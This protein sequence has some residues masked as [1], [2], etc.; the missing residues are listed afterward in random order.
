MG[1]FGGCDVVVV[2]AGFAGLSAAE[3]LVRAGL[4][5]RVLEAR[6]RVGGRVLTHYLPDGT[7]LDLGGQWIGPSQRNMADLVGRYVID[8]YPTPTQGEMVV[9]YDGRRLSDT[10]AEAA[11]ILGEIDV[12]ARQ[13]NV[14][15]PWAGARADEWDACTFASWLQ[16]SNASPASRRF[17]DRVVSGGSLAGSASETSVLE[18]LFYIA[19]A[20]GVE[21]LLGFED[22][23]QDT[24]IV[25]GAQLIAER[26]AAALPAGTVRLDLSWW[27]ASSTTPPPGSTPA[28]APTTPSE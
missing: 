27:R 25:G 13:V 15:Q 16:A 8:T 20:G 14:E 9:Q 7:Q 22:G 4:T 10:P 18:T 6:A 1:R 21:P 24:R 11:E 28:A 3:A 17:V 26:M 5:V 2:R 23:A 19:S 12:L